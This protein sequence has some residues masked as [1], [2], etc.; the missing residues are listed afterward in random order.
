MN[1]P[2][3][4]T[5]IG[6]TNIK[7]HLK[8]DRH[9]SIM[10]VIENFQ[11]REQELQKKLEEKEKEQIEYTK[12]QE[13]ERLL[14]NQHLE[15]SNFE[16]EQDKIKLQKQLKETNEKLRITN[17]ENKR[18]RERNNSLSLSSSKQISI[19][20][21]SQKSDLQNLVGKRSAFSFYLQINKTIFKRRHPKKC[22]NYRYQVIISAK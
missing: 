1:C 18:L 2:C 22:Y 6:K 19:N 9:K 11:K 16:K 3:G 7:E 4:A 5:N 15:K 13:I 8:S 17:L 10:N 20:D 14:F 21:I 12:Q